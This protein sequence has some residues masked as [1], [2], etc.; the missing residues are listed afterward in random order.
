ME[1]LY[2]IKNILSMAI[3]LLFIKVDAQNSHPN[4]FSLYK[5][6]ELIKK[7]EV[8]LKYDANYEERIINDK[9]VFIYKNKFL[10][11]KKEKCEQNMKVVF[12]DVKDLFLIE[13]KVL[14]KH[15]NET[16][17]KHGFKPVY[18]L[19]HIALKIF[20]IKNDECFV[21]DWMAQ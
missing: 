21:V 18:P 3:I 5:D 4:H 2:V 9:Q 17:K 16:E 19:K 13:Q 6:G 12:S 10:F 7:E 8:Y 11:T 14:E 1:N 20:L 15:I